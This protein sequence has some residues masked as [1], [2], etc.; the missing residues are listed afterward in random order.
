MGG[1]LGHHLE[2][3][4]I[5]TGKRHLIDCISLMNCFYWCQPWYVLYCTYIHTVDRGVGCRHP[6]T[7]LSS[8]PPSP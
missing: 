8:P 7:L 6:P 4:Q 3:K 5:K 1:G 2:K